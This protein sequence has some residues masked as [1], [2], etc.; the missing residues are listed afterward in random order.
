MAT[1]A[2]IKETRDYVLLRI[3]RKLIVPTT[4]EK[5][6]AEG[7]LLALSREAVK[8]Y[9]RDKLPLLRSLRDLR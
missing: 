1:I 7:K 9:R 3:P 2:I 8:L 6:I 4:K 5:K